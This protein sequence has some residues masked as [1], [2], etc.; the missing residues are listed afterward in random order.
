MK[1]SFLISILLLIVFK[2]SV[3]Q[4]ADSPPIV[5]NP[6]APV[7]V[8]ENSPVTVL[9]LSS[10]F[11]DPED[12]VITLSI[13]G[14]SNNT[15]VTPALSGTNLSLA[16]ALNQTGTSTITIRATADGE[17]TDTTFLVTVYASTPIPVFGPLGLLVSILGLLW[18]GVRQRKV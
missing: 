5:A 17:T 12:Y 10:V 16:Y 8:T 7:V 2:V 6:I 3:A 14:N 18:F 9:D 15:L 1:R 4:A 13:F 11:T